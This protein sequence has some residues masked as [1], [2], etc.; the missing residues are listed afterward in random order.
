VKQASPISDEC[1]DAIDARVAEIEKQALLVK[2]FL[3]DHVTD[4]QIDSL[5]GELEGITGVENVEYV[6]KEA[7]LERAK[8][9][10][11]DS[12]DVME[13]L[14]GNPFPASL[15]IAVDE[16]DDVEAVVDVMDGRPGVDD[17]G[18]G[19]QKALAA[20]ND[21]REGGMG[22]EC[23]DTFEMMSNDAREEA[24]S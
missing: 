21:A 11:K 16:I 18:T 23:Q 3:S 14:P 19:G 5:R 24:E 15:D 20:L 13:N 7:S 9:L 6:T 10:F 2:V 4:S 22:R 8:A 12:P 17:V 1:R